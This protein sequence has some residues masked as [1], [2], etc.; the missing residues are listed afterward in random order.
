MSWELAIHLCLCLA[1]TCRWDAMEYDEKLARF[2]QAHL[3]PFNKQL[4]PR[5]HEQEASEEAPDVASEGGCQEEICVGN[6]T[7]HTNTH[8]PFL[9]SAVEVAGFTPELGTVL[10]ASFSPCVPLQTGQMPGQGQAPLG[11]SCALPESPGPFWPPATPPSSGEK[12]D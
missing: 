6:V 5:Q 2:R 12:A 9:V 3:N 4:G 7:P 1:L 11:T 8:P 10:A